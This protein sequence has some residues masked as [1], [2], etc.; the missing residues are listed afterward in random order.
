MRLFRPTLALALALSA[1][2][3]APVWAQRAHHGRRHAAATSTPA[4][5]SA[6]VCRTRARDYAYD[7][8][9]DVGQERLFYNKCMG[10]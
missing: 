3:A 4:N 1:V 5:A 7:K 10:Q 6:A 9:A 8:H 2:T